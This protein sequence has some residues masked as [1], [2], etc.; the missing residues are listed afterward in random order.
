MPA[1][2][3]GL[4]YVPCAGRYVNLSRNDYKFASITWRICSVRKHSVIIVVRMRTLP[5]LSSEN[6][7]L[8]FSKG[9]DPS[10]FW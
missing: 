10:Y 5:I 9:R 7:W 3:P 4:Q 1:R 8:H 2:V 6:T